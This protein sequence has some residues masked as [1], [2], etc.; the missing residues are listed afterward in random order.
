MYWNHLEVNAGLRDFSWNG[1]CSGSVGLR[2]PYFSACGCRDRHPA[3]SGGLKQSLNITGISEHLSLCWWDTLGHV[4]S[5]VG[6]AVAGHSHSPRALSWNKLQMGRE[7][8]QG[9]GVLS[10][11]AVGFHRFAPQ[12]CHDV[13]SFSL[14][15]SCKMHQDASRCIMRKCPMCDASSSLDIPFLVVS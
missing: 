11:S 3:G 9:L 14:G 13:S 7:A 1:E 5:D 2:L 8:Q 4:G 10:R 12:N 15:T 6:S